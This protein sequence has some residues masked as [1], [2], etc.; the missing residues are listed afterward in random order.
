MFKNRIIFIAFLMF[1]STEMSH[2]QQRPDSVCV[3]VINAVRGG[4]TDLSTLLPIVLQFA[5]SGQTPNAMIKQCLQNYP[6]L[7]QQV[8]GGAAPNTYPNPNGGYPPPRY[9][10]GGYPPPPPPPRWA[11]GC[12]TQYGGC[13]LMQPVPMGSPCFCVMP[14][15][16]QA[17]GQAR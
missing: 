10:N 8:F 12:Y 13:R 4:K 16:M 6:M 17:P 14:N 15:G 7:L 9:P 11:T 2:A 3:Q 1:A 5:L